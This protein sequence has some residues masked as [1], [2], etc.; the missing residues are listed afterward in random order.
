M[1]RFVAGVLALFAV[2]LGATGCGKPEPVQ[3]EAQTSYQHLKAIRQAYMRA[4]TEL[5]RPPN[6][7]KEILP[8]MQNASGGSKED[9]LLSPD[10]GQEYKILWGVSGDDM[11]P[12]AD[13]HYPILAY[14]QQGKDGMRYVLAVKDITTMTDEQLKK[15]PFPPGHKSPFQGSD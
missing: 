3:K 9:L 12:D 10:D 13:G 14:E 4:T 8:Y 5:G 11:Q 2:C 1:L 7:A 15:A 6:N